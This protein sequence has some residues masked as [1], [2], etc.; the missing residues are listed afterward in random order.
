MLQ[1][2]RCPVYFEDAAP[3]TNTKMEQKMQLARRAIMVYFR[4]PTIGFGCQYLVNQGQVL[5]ATP[6]RKLLLRVGDIVTL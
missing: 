6:H 2:V 5:P 3:P 4:P 1:S